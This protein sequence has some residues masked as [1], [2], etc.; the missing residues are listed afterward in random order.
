MKTK[1]NKLARVLAGI[2]SVVSVCI[3]LF[4]V[5]SVLTF[6]RT[7][8]NLFG[9]KA[10]IVLSDSMSATD[11][12]AGDL[13][14]TRSVDPS[15]L[16]P[17][18]I[19][20]FVSSNDENYGETV[21]HKIRALTTT[22]SGEPGFI[23]YGTTT[24][25]DDAAVV[26]YYD[27]LG[28]Y[29]G[30]L[31]KVGAFFNFLK[32]TP[33]YILCIFVPFALLIFSQ[34]VETV[35]LFR[36]YKKEEMD[37][38]QSE[39]DSLKAQ[40]EETRRMQEELLQMKQQMAAGSPAAA[41]QAMASTFA[42]PGQQTGQLVAETLA[43]GGEVTLQ[44][45]V[46]FTSAAGQCLECVVAP[47]KTAVLDLNGF[48]LSGSVQLSAGALLIV[49]GKGILRADSRSYSSVGCAV[50]A[51]GEGCRAQLFDGHFVGGSGACAVCASSGE[52]TILGGEYSVQGDGK[53]TL[54]Q[55]GNGQIR[56]MGGYFANFD[57]SPMLV[58]GKKAACTQGASGL[59]YSV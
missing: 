30:H 37:H 52:I 33:G 49:K 24:G 27:V 58:P 23:T 56:V 48:S 16:Q 55:T 19:I 59:V 6:N 1:A 7:D 44:N 57:P 51:K 14:L 35:N 41:P 36:A 4:T 9:Y 8:R 18:D 31:P 42:L 32:T 13:V 39:R 15:T 20:A 25:T 43:G 10:F 26:T 29:A 12:A 54:Y 21:T 38:L 11:F 40:A 34:A 53:N 45:D 22:E 17:G 47:G 46:V 3:M 28:K 2:L 5:V 50:F